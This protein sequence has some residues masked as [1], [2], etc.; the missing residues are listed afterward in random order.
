MVKLPYEVT[1]QSFSSYTTSGYTGI[2]L[3]EPKT[4]ENVGSV[5]R[6]VYNFSVGFVEIVKPHCSIQKIKKIS[7][8]VL[9]AHRHVPVFILDEILLPVASHPVL[10]E[11]ST[12]AASLI[13][14]AHPRSAVYIFGPENGTL[15]IKGVPIVSIPVNGCLNLAQT[16]A[17]V[18][19]DRYL[20]TNV[21]RQEV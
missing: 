17:V 3:V 12:K 6:L 2:I 1:R 20:K 15:L 10:I 14:F 18:L 7:T 5:F 11:V 21:N 9:K 19:W 16:V 4:P 13:S 8:D